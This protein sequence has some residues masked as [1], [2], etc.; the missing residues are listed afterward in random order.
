MGRELV[1]YEMS[2]T[3]QNKQIRKRVGQ[4]TL[5]VQKISSIF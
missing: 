4:H 5:K 3:K 2:C 1:N